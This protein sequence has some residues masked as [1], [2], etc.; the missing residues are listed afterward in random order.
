MYL[1]GEPR[2]NPIDDYLRL[3]PAEEKA[4]LANYPYRIDP[5]TDDA[6]F[7]FQY[8]KWKNLFKE[9]TP[10]W[11]YYRLPPLGLK[12]LLF[13]LI[14][15]TLLGLL[16]IG[17]PLASH[18][19]RGAKNRL[20]PLL[21]FAA[22]GLGYILIEIV[23]IQKFNYFLGGAAYALA[24]TL[25]ALL[26]FS[27]LGSLLAGKREATRRF[28][29]TI[30]LAVIGAGA[31]LLFGLDGIL[32]ILMPFGRP[33]RIL[34]AVLLIAPLGLLMGIPFP[35]GIR[36]LKARDLGIIIPWAWGINSIFTVFGS[37]F[38]LLVSLSWG[39]SAA[40]LLGLGAYAAA[41]AC[42]PRLFAQG[43]PGRT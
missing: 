3:P 25:F 2:D 41:L 26:V 9:K 23:L 20:F 12:I 19:L 4:Y 39:F 38:C 6:P 32:K 30:L 14:Q 40:F 7:F 35:S 27:G 17:A 21:Y 43:I 11:V 18:G 42:A 15:V 29:L 10:E 8:Y 22:L 24:V 13:S 28:I 36:M 33:L 16:V 1:P 34:S 31:L 5:A 37:V